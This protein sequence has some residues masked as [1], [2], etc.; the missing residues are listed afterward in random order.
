MRA[1]RR[2]VFPQ[3]IPEAVGELAAE[4]PLTAPAARVLWKRGYRDAGSVR[5]FLRPQLADLHDPTRM[6]DMRK[7][8]ERLARAVTGGENILLYGDYD[9]DGIVA[10]VILKTVIDLAGGTA[11]YHVPDRFTEGYGMRR[12]VVEQ[13][14]RENVTLIVSVDTGIR[15]CEAVGRAAELGIDVVVTDHHLP[16]E[17]L[18][19]AY[20]ILN[21]NQPGCEYPERVLC[22]AGIAMKL[23]EALLDALGWE[24]ERRLRLG[25]SL[26]KLVAVATVADVVP[27]TG[28][29]RTVVLHG[30]EGFRSLRNPG[31]RALFDGAGFVPGECPTAGQVAFR[32]APRINA[33][34]R[35]STADDAVRLF[36]TRDEQEA[37]SIADQ[38]Q[39]LN[40]ERQREETKV[41]DEILDGCARDET[42]ASHEALVFSGE[43][44]HR[45]VLGIVA[46]RLVE[47]FHRPVF[48]L[49]VDSGESLARG[50]GRSIRGFHLLDALESMSDLFTKYG[51]HRQAA[52]VTMPADSVG[53]FRRRLREHA[54][55][56]L[57]PEDFV[58]EMELD[59]WLDFDELDDRAAA[60]ILSLAPFGMGN[61]APLFAVRDAEVRG[62]PRIFGEKHLR[63]QLRQ[64]GRALPVK[65]WNFADRIDE[66]SSGTRLDAALSVEKDDYQANRGGPG[67]GLVLR[68]VR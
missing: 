60:D 4:V 24:G 51:G 48:V 8:A 65:A 37:R 13:A 35:M 25:A 17:T 33:A 56:H 6:L 58:P 18:P 46:S 43:G 61:P 32:L 50:S 22:G 55:S 30:L 42:I 12:E 67:W 62:D 63:L 44:W 41:L 14:A 26:M 21:P 47:R 57:A 9:V 59:T 36:L 40:Q 68:D 45:G 38:L 16:T 3:D 15:A 31:L 1:P 34:G 23:I 52:G 20:A 49:S 19:P 5:G 28:E 11:T 29:N 64:N 27:L 39:R 7:A 54:A 10:V 66:M 2:W 53:P